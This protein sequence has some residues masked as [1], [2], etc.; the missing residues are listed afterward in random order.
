MAQSVVFVD[1]AVLGRLP[2]VCVIEGVPT[3]D[4]ATITQEVGSATSLGIAWLLLVLG[5]IG[6][7]GL[8]V[9]AALRGRGEVLT[10]NLPYSTGALARANRQIRSRRLAALVL[11]CSLVGGLISLSRARTQ[12]KLLAVALA[13]V[14]LAALVEATAASMRLRRL[15][16]G[17]GLDASRRWVTLSGVHP[18]FAA[19]VGRVGTVTPDTLRR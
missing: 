14:G 18:N 1:D 4:R 8:L 11:A 2:P 12:W 13:V 15:T 19:A 17:L 5:P 7:L 9:I 10:V 6:W 16:V 3:V